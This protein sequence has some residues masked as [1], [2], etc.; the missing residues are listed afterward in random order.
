MAKAPILYDLMLLLSTEA[1]DDVR[2][3]ILADVESTIAAAGGSVQRNDDWGRRTMTFEIN[4]QKD[5]EYK[6]LQFTG[7]TA[8]LESLSH[9][10]S[11]ADGVLRFRII[12]V[13]PGTPDAPD[14]KVA[15]APAPLPV[16]GDDDE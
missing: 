12:K 14:P 6:L 1:E 7:P 8:L 3:K 11:I 13:I 5:A 15:A 4:H 16:G 9:N 2:A 10:L